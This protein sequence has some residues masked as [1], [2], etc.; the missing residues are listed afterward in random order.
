MAKKWVG[1]AYRKICKPKY[2]NMR[3][4]VFRKTRTLITADGSNDDWIKPEGLPNYK[5]L[6]LSVLDPQPAAPSSS[7]SH[8][9]E[10][11]E[12]HELADDFEEEKFFEIVIENE[13]GERN[14]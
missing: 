4:S 14:I 9:F 1:R 5:I 6:P 2:I 7:V 11:E 3:Y 13:L 12:Q 10:Q 8:N